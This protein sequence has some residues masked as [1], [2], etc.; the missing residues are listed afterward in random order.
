MEDV[1]RFI[2]GS[3]CAIGLL[4][5]PLAIVVINDRQKE[6]IVRRAER[7]GREPPRRYL[8]YKTSWRMVLGLS[9]VF[10]A[11]P[12]LFALAQNLPALDRELASAPV[13][14]AALCLVAMTVITV[15]YLV[16][17]W[18]NRELL[19]VH[20]LA[21]SGDVDGAITALRV[22]IRQNG[23]SWR[24][25]NNLAV[26]LGHQSRW[27][28]ALAAIEEA[29]RILP[30]NPLIFENKGMIQLKLGRREEAAQTWEVARR[31]RPDDLMLTCQYGGLLAEL[32]HSEEAARLLR[33]A[34]HLYSSQRLLSWVYRRQRGTALQEFRQKV[35]G[36]RG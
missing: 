21:K 30:E 17:R 1:F 5:L 33:E 23:P 7:E 24:M 10:L 34:D 18:K 13:L 27:E 36:N 14:F 8:N 22:L 4:L 16:D 3:V 26:Y 35:A 9:L 28:E 2:V 19:G 11:L 32:G 29:E 25:Y 15:R 12:F 31:N 20:Q 6:R